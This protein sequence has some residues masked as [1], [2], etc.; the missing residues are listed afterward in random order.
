MLGQAEL[1]SASLRNGD[2]GGGAAIP[3]MAP[4]HGGSPGSA[5]GIVDCAGRD[6][7]ID[8]SDGRSNAVLINWEIPAA[9]RTSFRTTGTVSF[10]FRA[11]RELHVGGAILGDSSGFTTFRN[12]QGTLG[13]VMGRVTN[14]TPEPD[15]TR[16]YFVWTTSPR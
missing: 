12:G 8:Q 5:T 14:D 16:L 7:Y 4:D 6:L 11:D 13:G 2:Y 9:N 10:S 3:T 1:F 15:S